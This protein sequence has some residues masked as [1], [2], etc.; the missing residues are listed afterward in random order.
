MP[1]TKQAKKQLVADLVKEISAN[2]EQVLVGYQ[3]LSVK[4]L[5]ELRRT[6]RKS[7]VSLR[8]LK[9][10]L[11]E[12]VLKE[13]KIEG[14]KPLEIKKP[15]ALVIGDDEVLPAK[16]LATFA[17]KHKKLELVA[18]VIDHKA[19]GVDQLKSLAALP[20]R[21]E[22]LGITVGTI[23]APISGFV[24]VLAGTSRA[25]VQVLSAWAKSKS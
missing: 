15:L 17:K 14:L 2:K 8:V 21:Q 22:M 4:E 5:E 10:T 18:G 11:L 20:T 6:L 25:L 16:M 7:K 1:I 9:N 19:V 3:G 23:V 13:S 12:R 24:R